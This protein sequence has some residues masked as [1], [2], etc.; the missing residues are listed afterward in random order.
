MFTLLDIHP[1]ER[2]ITLHIN[3][4]M[5]NHHLSKSGFSLLPDLSGVCFQGRGL[6]S[7]TF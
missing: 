4:V 6:G 1:L 5:E 7:D 3:I 2:K